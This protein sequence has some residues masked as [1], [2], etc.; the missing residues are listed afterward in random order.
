[1]MLYLFSS[2]LNNSTLMTHIVWLHM[3]FYIWGSTPIILL[4]YF[5]LP[6]NNTYFNFL[7]F[8]FNTSK[9]LH[10]IVVDIILIKKSNSYF[11]SYGLWKNENISNSI[12]Y[13]LNY[14]ISPFFKIFRNNLTRGE[15]LTFS[16]QYHVENLISFLLQ[17]PRDIWTLCVI[18]AYIYKKVSQDSKCKIY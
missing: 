7:V 1:M 6:S 14:M 10:I 4:Q 12:W 17:I 2:H 3:S 11:V 18:N 8:C 16:Q 15:T 13:V 5:V 9:T